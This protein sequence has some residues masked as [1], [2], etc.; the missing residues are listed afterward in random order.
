[1]SALP[2]FLHGVGCHASD[3]L[4][5]VFDATINLKLISR[6]EHACSVANN[7]TVGFNPHIIEWFHVATIDLWPRSDCISRNIHH[8]CVF[9]SRL[10]FVYFFNFYRLLHVSV[11]FMWHTID[12]RLESQMHASASMAKVQVK[13]SINTQQLK[14]RGKAKRWVFFFRWA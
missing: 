8:F 6:C 14:V 12:K 2:A 13:L 5:V 3:K 1:M 9:P 7:D 4:S 10:L 11:I